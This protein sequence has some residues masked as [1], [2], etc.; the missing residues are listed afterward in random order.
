MLGDT[1]LNRDLDEFASAPEFRGNTLVRPSR[2]RQFV[3]TAALFVAV[4]LAITGLANLI[5]VLS[6]ADP[7]ANS[8]AMLGA[9]LLMLLAAL[10]LIWRLASPFVFA[11]AVTDDSLH[12]RTIF[13]W[14]EAP[15]DEIEFVL[16][17]PHSRFG[18]RAVHIK[19]GNRRMHYG[20]FDSTD[21]Y[22]FGPLE[23]LPADEAKSL[24]HTIVSRARLVRRAPGVWVND[25]LDQ[26]VEVSTGQFKW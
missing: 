6:R 16:V 1:V 2:T 13:G 18:G 20:W 14:H 25:R 5:A 10:G 3:Y 19:A 22:T 26:P 21:W 12:W 4:L 24:T 23:S 15:W 7:S 9:G 11:T 17:E 8:T